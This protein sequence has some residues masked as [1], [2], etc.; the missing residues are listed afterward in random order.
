M[1][2]LHLTR[3]EENFTHLATARTYHAALRNLAAVALPLRRREFLELLFLLALVCL[4]LPHGGCW[5]QRIAGQFYISLSNDISRFA[6][7][8]GPSFPVQPC[9]V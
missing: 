1:H 6:Q 4:L 3:F 5:H 8:R 7:T 9:Q 2:G